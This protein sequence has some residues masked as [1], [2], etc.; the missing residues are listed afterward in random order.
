MVHHKKTWPNYFED[1]VQGRKRFDIRLAD[2]V[3][4]VGDTIVFEEWD[5]KTGA[6]TGRKLEKKVS[7]RVLTKDLSYWSSDD[8]ET[9]GYQIL[10][11]E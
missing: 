5:P 1:L 10:Q 7:Y 3:V 9:Y 4:A 8:V 2:F 11:L 6:F